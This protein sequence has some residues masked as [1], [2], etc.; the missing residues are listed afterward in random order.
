MTARSR[1]QGT[2]LGL[3]LLFAGAGARAQAAR[4]PPANYRVQCRTTSG[5]FTLAI[6]R[7]WAPRGASRFYALLAAH[8]YQGS[9]F[10]RVIPGF[11]AQWGLS[12]DPAV[13]ARWQ[14]R[15]IP[16]DPVRVSNRKG[17][18]SFADSGRNSRTTV[19][20]INLRNN[21]DLDKKGFAPFGE[22]VAGMETVMELD[23]SY[24]DGPPR[25]QGP[26]PELIEREGAAYLTRE[27]PR[28]DVIYGCRVEGATPAPR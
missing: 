22:V 18:I 25:G 17:T 15:R 14:R 19:V 9:A 5:N 11:V 28:L 26:N 16:D 6:H 23:G 13:S 4:Q 8:Y 12:P 24:G 27:F 7:A 10:Y 3:L 20:F 21:R 2:T 1:R